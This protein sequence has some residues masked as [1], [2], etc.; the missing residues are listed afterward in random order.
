MLQDGGGGRCY[1]KVKCADLMSV[2]YRGARGRGDRRNEI[3]VNPKC[4]SLGYDVSDL[5]LEA[6]EE[7]SSF[8][9]DMM[10]MSITRG[11]D[12][13]QYKKATTS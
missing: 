5:V 10:M 11:G 6:I 8:G 9:E 3:K 13:N 12:K 1:G 4:R 2:G 7:S